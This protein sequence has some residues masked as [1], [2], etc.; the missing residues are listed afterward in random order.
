MVGPTL[1]ILLDKSGISLGFSKRTI[2]MIECRCM[3]MIGGWNIDGYGELVPPA[4]HTY[5]RAIYGIVHIDERASGGFKILF[6]KL[7]EKAT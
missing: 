5:S 1:V 7:S 2:V 4:I 6:Q 3:W